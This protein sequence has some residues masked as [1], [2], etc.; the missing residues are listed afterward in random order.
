MLYIQI[1]TSSGSQR[2]FKMSCL[3][4]NCC[5]ARKMWFQ[6][7]FFSQSTSLAQ[8]IVMVSPGVPVPG[9]G[10]TSSYRRCRLGL[11]S[12]GALIFVGKTPLS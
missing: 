6:L 4:C 8:W 11:L 1:T 12:L 3:R 7:F 9:A 2:K 10:G 5:A